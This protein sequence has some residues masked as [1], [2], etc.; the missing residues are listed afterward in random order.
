MCYVDG[1][2]VQLTYLAQCPGTTCDAANAQTLEWVIYIR[3]DPDM[4]I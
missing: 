3:I 1:Y 4:L 2:R